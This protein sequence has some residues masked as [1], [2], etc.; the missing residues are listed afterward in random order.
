MIFS[1]QEWSKK[2]HAH[3]CNDL[4]DSPENGKSFFPETRNPQ[5]WTSARAKSRRK[6]SLKRQNI[7]PENK[8][9]RFGDCFRGLC[10]I[11]ALFCNMV[12][13]LQE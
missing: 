6:Q 12:T 4:C 1:K 2:G 5:K 7:F 3:F 10:T 8:N 11:S 9:P 13:L